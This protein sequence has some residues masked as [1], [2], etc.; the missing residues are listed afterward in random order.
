MENSEQESKFERMTTAPVRKL[1]CSMAVPSI[2]SMLVTAFY[3][4][5]DTFFVGKI[6]T[7]ATG[8]LGIVFSY[9]A[10]V[11]AITYQGN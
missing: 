11:Q 6:S 10:L 7:Q 5:A 9:M 4:M 8:A 1:V 2:A 3:N